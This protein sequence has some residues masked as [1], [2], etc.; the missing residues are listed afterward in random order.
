[1][2]HI[3]EIKVQGLTGRKKVYSCRLNRDV[4]IFFGL[5]GSGK[6]S[7]L[8]IMHSA[9][10]GETS[11][12]DGVAFESAEVSIYS[13][14]QD[15]IF[16]YSIK[17]FSEQELLQAELF[18]S[19]SRVIARRRR[20]ML[21]RKHLKWEGEPAKGKKRRPGAWSHR[22]LPTSRLY[23]QFEEY[24]DARY[25]E[26]RSRY[27]DQ[28]INIYFARFIEQL[29][30]S[31][32]RSILAE[33]RSAQERGLANVLKTVLAP[34]AES[35]PVGVLETDKAYE[36]LGRFLKR[37][38][39]AKSLSTAKAFKKRYAEDLRLRRVVNEINEVEE[40]IDK[41]M[42]PQRELESLIQKMFSGGKVVRFSEGAIKVEMGKN[43]EIPLSSLSSGEKQILRLF[44]ETLLAA[45][46]TILIDEPEISM[47]IDWQKDLVT[48]MQRLNPGAQ[49]VLATH[50]PEVM[51]D[52]KD[53][54]IFKL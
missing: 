38:K 25:G 9:M 20:E 37:Q 19:Q 11:I 44:V 32:S 30:N 53:S 46:N 42:A 35:E 14:D 36:R 7:L 43:E 5:N 34:E 31:Y 39:S 21:K 51:A 22:Y 1:M 28:D 12:L 17:Q 49:L 18:E 3:T 8:K 50:S 2:A 15:R 27:N 29:W 6:T 40:H 41:A 4:N 54:N 52:I 26:A 24:Y 13:I 10:S 47:H 16:V 23:Q 45:D 48:A 33:V